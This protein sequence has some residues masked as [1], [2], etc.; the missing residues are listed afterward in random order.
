[1]SARNGAGLDHGDGEAREIEKGTRSFSP[2]P[3]QASSNRKARLE[4]A[5]GILLALRQRWPDTFPRLS[6]RTRRPLKIGIGDDIIAA[7]PDIPPALISLALGIY[8]NSAPYFVA[9][10]TGTPRIDLDGKPAG[11]VSPAEAAHAREKLEQRRP[12][13]PKP[14]P[15]PAAPRRITLSDLRAAAARRRNMGAAP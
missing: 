12:K 3:T 14:S 1:M 5:T 13:K 11:V 6:A 2:P 15:A 10:T 9:C 8:V 4:A 7:L